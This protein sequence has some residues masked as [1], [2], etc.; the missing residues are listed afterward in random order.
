MRASQRGSLAEGQTEE[1]DLSK[2]HSITTE[3]NDSV[4]QLKMFALLAV[5]LVFILLAMSPSNRA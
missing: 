3:G 2:V 4:Y 1:H 5:G